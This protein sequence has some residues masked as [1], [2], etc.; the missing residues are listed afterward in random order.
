MCVVACAA[1]CS[2]FL[3]C[4]HV[5]LWCVPSF[6]CVLTCL[7]GV[8]LALLSCLTPTYYSFYAWSNGTNPT[9]NAASSKIQPTQL[10]YSANDA[11]LDGKTCIKFTTGGSSTEQKQST[12]KAHT[13]SKAKQSKTLK[14]HTQS[15]HIHTHAHT[16]KAHTHTHAH[17]KQSTQSEAKQSKAKQTKHTHT[18]THVHWNA[19][20][21]AS[22]MFLSPLLFFRL[23]RLYICQQQCCRIDCLIRRSRCHDCIG[24]QPH[25]LNT[26]HVPHQLTH[27]LLFSYDALL[28]VCIFGC[29]LDNVL[30][31]S[32]LCGCVVLCCSPSLSFVSCLFALC[33]LPRFRIVFFLSFARV[34]LSPVLLSCVC[35]SSCP[36]F[37]VF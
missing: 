8:C 2:L 10:A 6:F 5:S 32:C 18:H 35:Y 16:H 4:A 14:A 24:A 1:V 27:L 9:C 26:H 7:C 20:L 33:V 34:T 15:T 37:C 19:M 23:S 31:V 3:L 12:H 29:D 11:G 36:L 25:A 17:T 22:H 30:V 28:C 13:Q 21:T